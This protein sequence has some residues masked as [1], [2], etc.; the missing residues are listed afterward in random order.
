MQIHCFLAIRLDFSLNKEKK[1][2]TKL[3][4]DLLNK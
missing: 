1:E 2:K 3:C 4:V